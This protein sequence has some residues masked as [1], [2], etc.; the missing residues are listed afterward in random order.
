MYGSHKKFL[1]SGP[2]LPVSDDIRSFAGTS[3][4]PIAKS[5]EGC[6]HILHSN[7]HKEIRDNELIFGKQSVYVT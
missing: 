3:Y 5:N 1:F 2:I 6:P 4:P 7:K